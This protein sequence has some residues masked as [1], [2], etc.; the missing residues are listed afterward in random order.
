M[1]HPLILWYPLLI[2][3]L[4]AVILCVD[5]SAAFATPIHS[6]GLS[7]HRW[8]LVGALVSGSILAYISLTR[9]SLPRLLSFALLIP[10]QAL[11]TMIAF[12]ALAAVL[13]G[14]YGDGVIRPQA[15]ILADQLPSILAAGFYTTA[16]LERQGVLFWKRGSY[17]VQRSSSP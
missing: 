5:Y 12:G 6:I 15:F 2:H 3:L 13:R 14:S 17:P 16:I 8:L 11:L 1:N 4:W 10:Q 7:S 9:T